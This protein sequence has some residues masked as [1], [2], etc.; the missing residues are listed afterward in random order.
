MFAILK[1]NCSLS[2]CNRRIYIYIEIN[3]LLGNE[4]ICKCLASLYDGITVDNSI[5]HMRCLLGC[6]LEGEVAAMD[7]GRHDPRHIGLRLESLRKCK[8]VD[9]SL[10]V[11]SG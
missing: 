2:I 4:R 3:I 1:Y 9:G 5:N 7:S 6:N 8:V 10:V 11:E